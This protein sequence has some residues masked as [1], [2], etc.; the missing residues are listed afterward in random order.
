[1]FCQP[2]PASLSTSPRLP[3]GEAVMAQEY[4]SNASVNGLSGD[5]YFNR[6]LAYW[7]TFRE[8]FHIE[9]PL[10]GKRV[11]DVGCGHGSFT[12]AA[13]VAGATAIG[14]DLVEAKLQIG[15]Q[16]ARARVMRP[17]GSVRFWCTDVV[18][19]RDEP[20]DIILSHETFEHLENLPAALE[21]L[22]SLLKPGG[23]LYAAWGPLW[24]SVFGG[25]YWLQKSL[26]GVPIPWSHRLFTN[27]SNRPG[28]NQLDY[29]A[30][31]YIIGASPFE[32]VSWEANVGDHWGYK[33]FRVLAKIP[34]LR[35]AFTQNVYVTLGKHRA[36]GG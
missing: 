4:L 15:W 20:F 32:I 7:P 17:R 26:F 2:P 29:K 5:A 33:V 36:N 3:P 12:V 35:D 27:R 16:Q 10:D 6:K 21:N 1:M 24:P 8:Y 22:Y 31:R 11:L 34:G 9:M 28:V 14:I 30:Y 13:G 23:R 18:R 25:H 19:Y